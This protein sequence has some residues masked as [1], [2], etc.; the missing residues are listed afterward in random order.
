MIEIK[1]IRG[2]VLHRVEADT[3]YGANLCGAT[4]SR[5]DL[6]D[7]NL[8]DADLCGAGLCGANLSRANLR[9]ANLSRAD[10]RDADLRY[11]DLSDALIADGVRLTGARPCVQIGPIG[12]RDGTLIGFRTDRGPYVRAGCWLGTL[13]DFLARVAEVHCDTRHRRDYDAACNLLEVML[14]E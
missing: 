8:C 13:S 6:C 3:L 11:A 7:A 1:T 14:C 9:Y 5:A 4:L 2:A 12:S 10:L